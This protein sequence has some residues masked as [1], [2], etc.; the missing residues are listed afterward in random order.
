[1]NWK[2]HERSVA[3]TIGDLLGITLRR[4]DAKYNAGDPARNSDVDVEH[5]KFSTF[6]TNGITIECKYDKDGF[7]SIYKWFKQ[8]KNTPKLLVINNKFVVFS[9]ENILDVWYDLINRNLIRYNI[10]QINTSIDFVG[11]SKATDQSKKYAKTKKLFP[12]LSIR[13]GGQKALVI[14]NLETLQNILNRKTNDN[15]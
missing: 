1:M 14:I 2:N 15:L 4:N 13:R 6:N 9:L 8:I 3:K 10:T 12:V 11:I 7:G 5:E